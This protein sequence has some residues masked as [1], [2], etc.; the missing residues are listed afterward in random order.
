[1]EKRQ[2]E[3]LVKERDHLNV[4]AD[5]RIVMEQ[6]EFE[7]KPLLRTETSATFGAPGGLVTWF[8]K[9]QSVSFTVVPA[10]EDTRLI[11]LVKQGLGNP[12]KFFDQVT[13]IVSE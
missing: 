4:M 12:G 5:L 13:E 1:M 10:G 8:F 3:F 9:S 6:N 2:E 11:V 7:E